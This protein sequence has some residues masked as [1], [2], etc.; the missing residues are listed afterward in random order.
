M[1]LNLDHAAPFTHATHF[2]T[3]GLNS[4]ILNWTTYTNSVRTAQ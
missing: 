3:L 2:A 4:K 1:W